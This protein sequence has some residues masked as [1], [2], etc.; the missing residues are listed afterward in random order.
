MTT[1][2]GRIACLPEFWSTTN[3]K[4]TFFTR[5]SLGRRSGV[6]ANFKFN[7]KRIN[8]NEKHR[9]RK[10][11]N[12]RITE[13]WK[14]DNLI[15]HIVVKSSHPLA[16]QSPVHQPPMTDTPAVDETPTAEALVELLPTPEVTT[17]ESISV[18]EASRTESPTADTSSSELTSAAESSTGEEAPAPSL[19]ISQFSPTTLLNQL[20]SCMPTISTTK[21]RQ[22]RRR[23]Q[24]ILKK[25][26]ASPNPIINSPTAKKETNMFTSKLAQ[27]HTPT[28]NEA[29]DAVKQSVRKL[30]RSIWPASKKP[31]SE[32]PVTPFAFRTNTRNWHTATSNLQECIVRL[33]TVLNANIEMRP[34]TDINPLPKRMTS[35]SIELARDRGAW[36]MSDDDHGFLI[37]E[38]RHREEGFEYNV[39][40]ALDS[41]RQEEEARIWQSEKYANYNSTDESQDGEQELV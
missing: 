41:Q 34:V 33:E 38:S 5:R 2:H 29:F 26:P 21:M 19:S 40:L 20:E 9:T 10:A 18:D 23:L 28:R 12:N 1:V 13:E 36:R 7:P 24:G 31:S 39:E 6:D 17:A 16:I 27:M 4:R 15:P 14:Y 30:Q 22:V 8:P 35:Q 3:A 25:T 11:H 32:D 37:E